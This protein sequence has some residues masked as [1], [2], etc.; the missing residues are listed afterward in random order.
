MRIGTQTIHPRYQLGSL[1]LKCILFILGLQHS[2]ENLAHAIAG[3]AFDWDDTPSDPLVMTELFLGPCLQPLHN[4]FFS[5]SLTSCVQNDPGTG[6]V[7]GGG[8]LGR[9]NTGNGNVHDKVV[10]LCKDCFFQLGR[11]DLA[12]MNLE[13]ILQAI[14]EA[15]NAMLLEK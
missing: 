12:T 15:A 7:V 6:S 14:N 4:L 10:R 13:G 3:D 8:Q 5:E 11:R 9:K 1:C 2:S